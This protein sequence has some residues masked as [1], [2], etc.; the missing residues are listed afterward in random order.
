MYQF[1]SSCLKS[2]KKKVLLFIGATFYRQKGNK[3]NPV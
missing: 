3:G 1:F 2:I